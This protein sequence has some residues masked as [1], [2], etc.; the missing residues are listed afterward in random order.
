MRGLGGIS[1]C[2][3]LEASRPAFRGR[4]NIGGATGNSMAPTDPGK[5]CKTLQREDPPPP[6]L[7][8]ANPFSSL[9]PHSRSLIPGTMSDYVPTPTI[10]ARRKFGGRKEQ[11]VNGGREAGSLRQDNPHRRS[12]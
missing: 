7:P 2:I 9:C 3:L 12:M 8:S 11:G 4:A 6:L 10:L 5:V 1:P